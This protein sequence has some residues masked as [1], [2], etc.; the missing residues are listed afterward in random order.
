[1]CKKYACKYLTGCIFEKRHP[2]RTN[3]EEVP[4]EEIIHMTERIKKCMQK[5]EICMKMLRRIIP[6]IGVR[7]ETKKNSILDDF[8]NNAI[9][10]SSMAGFPEDSTGER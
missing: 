10:S 3:K 7:K 1:M 8:V 2:R 5:A 4:Q 9:C 6:N